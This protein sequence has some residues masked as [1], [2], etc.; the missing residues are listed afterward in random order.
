MTAHLLVHTKAIVHQQMHIVASIPIIPLVH[1][2]ARATRRQ[3]V[4]TTVTY[5][6]SP[7]GSRPRRGIH[8]CMWLS[9]SVGKSPAQDS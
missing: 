2:D 4:E 1:S 8:T 5:V 6:T 3:T 9:V 7:P